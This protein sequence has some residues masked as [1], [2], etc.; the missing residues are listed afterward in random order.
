[1]NIIISIDLQLNFLAYIREGLS[2]K[3][4]K[5]VYLQPRT[6]E[7]IKNISP[8]IHKHRAYERHSLVAKRWERRRRRSVPLARR[9]TPPPEQRAADMASQGKSLQICTA[10]RWCFIGIST[11]H[12][13]FYYQH[14]QKGWTKKQQF[15]IN[16]HEK[17]RK[18]LQSATERKKNVRHD[19]YWI[20]TL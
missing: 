11:T 18:C 17:K 19:F 4:W 5:I 6:Q 14:T 3:H 15:L 1:M 10:S 9:R 2:F 20:K 16:M 13:P 12:I 7:Y 8:L